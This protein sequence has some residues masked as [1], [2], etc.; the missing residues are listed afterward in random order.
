MLSA[1]IRPAKY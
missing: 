1:S